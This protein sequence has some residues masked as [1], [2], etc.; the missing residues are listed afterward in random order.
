MTE[1]TGLICAADA[2]AACGGG[3]RALYAPIVWE[4][5]ALMRMEA[6]LALARPSVVSCE[7]A[8]RRILEMAEEALPL[9]ERAM[10]AT[11]RDL[12]DA[13]DDVEEIRRRRERRRRAT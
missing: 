8:L 6:E 12:Q 1:L 10:G 4:E 3:L 13:R 11:S 7:R 5:I 9:Q 2:Q